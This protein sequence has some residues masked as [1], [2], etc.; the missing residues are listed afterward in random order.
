MFHRE[1][2]LEFDLDGGKG[3]AQTNIYLDVEFYSITQRKWPSHESQVPKA[4]CKVFKKPKYIIFCPFLD[5]FVKVCRD[6]VEF[7]LAYQVCTQVCL[8]KYYKI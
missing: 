5:V 2:A 4:Q 8:V 6:K 1:H 7:E 3:G